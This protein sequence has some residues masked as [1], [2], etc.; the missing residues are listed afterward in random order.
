MDGGYETH[1][2]EV[3][4]VQVAGGVAVDDE[5]GDGGGVGQGD[6]VA[7]VGEDGLDGVGVADEEVAALASDD[8]AADGG[9]VVQDE[10]GDAAVDGGVH[11]A[12]EA[13]V[14]GYDDHTDAADR[15]HLQ[16][17]VGGVVIAGGLGGQE[18]DDLVDFFGVGAAVGYRQLGAAHFG[19]RNQRHRIGD[20]AGVFHAAD[21]AA[22]VS[23]AGHSA[24][25]WCGFGAANL[26]RRCRGDRL[27]AAFLFGWLGRR[28]V[29]P[30]RLDSGL[31]R[32]DG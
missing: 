21:A 8:D 12:G 9:R 25:I 1:I 3:D 30:R 17:R 19:G 18:G 31:R 16:Q 13:P 14:G 32:N 7:E 26:G 2:G 20:F 6:A 28:G 24:S 5:A 29:F 4:F 10:L 23:N 11:S 15:A 22:D 27:E